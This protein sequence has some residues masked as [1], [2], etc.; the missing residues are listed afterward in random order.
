MVQHQRIWLRRLTTDL[1]GYSLDCSSALNFT[2]C[3]GYDAAYL[4]QQCT[5]DSQYSSSCPGYVD[6]NATNNSGLTEE[7][8]CQINPA[9]SYNCYSYFSNDGSDNNDDGQHGNYGD[10][11][12]DQFGNPDD[13]NNSFGNNNHNDQGNQH[14]SPSGGRNDHSGS[15]MGMSNPNEGSFSGSSDNQGPGG[16]QEFNQGPAPVDPYQD[17]ATVDMMPYTTQP[18][19]N[20]DTFPAEHHFNAHQDQPDGNP[21]QSS[22][23]NPPPVDVATYGG[24]EPDHLDVFDHAPHST[25]DTNRDIDPIVDLEL[26]DLPNRVLDDIP[27]ITRAEPV[28]ASRE[29]RERDVEDEI[30]ELEEPQDRPA[31]ARVSRAS[32]PVVETI[33][34]CC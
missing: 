8:Q 16:S 13:T 28:A 1:S 25:H 15:D 9:Y 27:S 17:P 6:P 30:R 19:H 4:D 3:P 12:N 26:A 33:S 5:I 18:Q 11:P 7:E 23:Q 29:P 20:V 34:R 31:I 14:G 21:H 2:Q 10:N 22:N 24:P 32:E